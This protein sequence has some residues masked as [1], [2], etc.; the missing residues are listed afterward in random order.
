MLIAA[1]LKEIWLMGLILG[2]WKCPEEINKAIM[3][4]FR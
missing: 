1:G 4:F 2:L 3:L